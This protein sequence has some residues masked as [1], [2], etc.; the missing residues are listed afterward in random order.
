MS[1]T[2]TIGKHSAMF[3]QY[4]N[5]YRIQRIPMLIDRTETIFAITPFSIQNDF[6]EKPFN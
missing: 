4:N 6:F 5:Y 2:I 3:V 1:I